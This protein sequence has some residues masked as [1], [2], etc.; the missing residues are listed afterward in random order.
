M[1][2]YHNKLS[3]SASTEAKC[4]RDGLVLSMHTQSQ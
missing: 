3:D 2:L 1:E 4:F